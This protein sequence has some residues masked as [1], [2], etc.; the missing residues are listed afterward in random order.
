MPQIIDRKEEVYEDA[1]E[2]ENPGMVYC[3]TNPENPRIWVNPEHA[4]IIK[5]YIPIR[6]SHLEFIKKLVN[7][8]YTSSVDR[9]C[10]DAVNEKLERTLKDYETLG[11]IFSDRLQSEVGYDTCKWTSYNESVLRNGGI[12]KQNNV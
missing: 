9:F 2:R 10:R 5:T 3:H 11:R 6:I 7:V 8:G 4:R 12:M 1:V